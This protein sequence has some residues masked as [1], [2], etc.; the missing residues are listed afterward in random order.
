MRTIA[1]IAAE[2]SKLWAK[3]NYAAKPYL[4]AMH[5][6]DTL[7]DNFFQDSAVSVV[8]YFLANATTFTGDDARRIK[9]E[10]NAMVR[11]YRLAHS[12]GPAW[13]EP[14]KQAYQY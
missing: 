3:P 7:A 2:I 11:E 9:K 10:L 8:S 14:T 12:R 1:A 13:N 4:D 5:Q 6:L